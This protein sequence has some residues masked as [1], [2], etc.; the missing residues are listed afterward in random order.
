MYKDDEHRG[1]DLL[2]KV[3]AT[4]GGYNRGNDLSL[5][6][7][8]SLYTAPLFTLAPTRMANTQMSN[9]I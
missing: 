2:F 1:N 5:S 3:F 4:G 9:N 6:L 7:S 8:L